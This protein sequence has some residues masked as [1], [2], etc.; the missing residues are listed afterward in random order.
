LRIGG[1]Q[2]FQ[3]LFDRE[4]G[5]FSHGKPHI[6]EAFGQ[7]QPRQ[8]KPVGTSYQLTRRDGPK[9]P[10]ERE[11]YCFELL[12]RIRRRHPLIWI[13]KSC[14][15]ATRGA[16]GAPRACQ[17]ASALKVVSRRAFVPDGVSGDPDARRA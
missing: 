16:P 2:F 11:A 4:L 14:A 17:V 15:A 10:A 12:L 5:C 6:Q 8:S 9:L 3:R 7:W 1:A 13:N